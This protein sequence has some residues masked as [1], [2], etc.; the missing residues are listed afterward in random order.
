MNLEFCVKDMICDRNQSILAR[1]RGFGL[2]TVTLVKLET[3]LIGKCKQ[4]ATKTFNRVAQRA[5]P[6]NDEALAPASSGWFLALGS[7]PM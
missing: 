7:N 1:I 3:C 6:R 4:R 5:V 2:P